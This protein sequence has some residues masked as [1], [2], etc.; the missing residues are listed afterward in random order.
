MPKTTASPSKENRMR[1][2]S[3]W[4]LL[5]ATCLP[6][7]A[8][9]A[10]EQEKNKQ[11]ARGFFEV[12][13]QGQLDKYAESHAQDFVVHGSD[14]DGTL[15]ED[16]AAAREERKAFP[17]MKMRVN[18]IVAE[19]D[20]VVVHWTASGTNTQ[21]GMGFP[22]T[23]KPMKISGMTLFRFQA[24]RICE[25]WNAWSMLSVMRQLGLIPSLQ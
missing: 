15:E 3:I 23:G 6:A 22:A 9:Q 20:L 2:H 14:H 10:G 25:E 12:L 17:D 16:L 4:L 1:K 5:F 13:D 19:R 8:Q 21:A 7:M 18:H 24:G 11:I